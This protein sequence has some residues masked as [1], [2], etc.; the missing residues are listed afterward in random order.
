M[1]GN[2]TKRIAFNYLGGKFTYVDEI[3]QYFPEHEH[4]VDVFCGSMAITL[5]KP[6]SKI[7]TA[8]DLNK[9]VINFFRV[10]REQ[11]EELITL[12]ELTPVARD[13]YKEAFYTQDDPAEPI[14]KARRFFVRARQSFYGLGA[15]RQNKGWHL[16]VKNSRSNVAETISK[17]NNAIDKLW[18]LIEPLR[19]IQIENTDY[20]KIITKID[21]PE[22][23]FYLDPPYPAESR[24]SGKDYKHDFTDDQHRELA[25]LA[26]GIKGKA[27]IS[28]YECPLMEELY[29]DWKFV[30][31]T[32]K[33]NG[34]RTKKVKECIW[35][36][37]EQHIPDF[38]SGLR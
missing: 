38:Y 14:E 25:E 16:T 24:S 31:L 4:F 18:W 30:P 7:D 8:N 23:F 6:P 27:M 33:M 11:P 12:L 22:A 3:I 9:D 26:H 13:E 5:N 21:Y 34:I 1:S 17:W 10:L 37:Y 28:G 36:N 35:M 2:K 20:K 32:Q 29:G 19:R 15:Q